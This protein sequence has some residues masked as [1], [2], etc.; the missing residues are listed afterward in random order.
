MLTLF[1][2][3]VFMGN[4]RL[5][6]R[7]ERLYVEPYKDGKVFE[8]RKQPHVLFLTLTEIRT[9]LGLY[10]DQEWIEKELTEET[11]SLSGEDRGYSQSFGWR[12]RATGELTDSDSISIIE[13]DGTLL[14][15]IYGECLVSLIAIEDSERGRGRGSLLP[16]FG[17]SLGLCL[18][19][20]L[21]KTELAAICNELVSGR[22][23]ELE[24]SVRID[25]FMSEVAE[26][27]GDIDTPR[28]VYIEEERPSKA[29][30]LSLRAS[31]L[32]TKRSEH[33]RPEN[34]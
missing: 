27:L 3:G 32:I 22:L 11:K 4:R 34:E 13:R 29:Y 18:E 26:G 21:P 20:S 14:D 33:S 31:K 16:P 23:S 8:W 7:N 6:K 5:E 24:L 1:G 17:G 12:I 28:T 19:L 2:A 15:G 10:I 25:G 30:L 9:V